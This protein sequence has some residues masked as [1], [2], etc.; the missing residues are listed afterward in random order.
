RAHAAA[1]HARRASRGEEG[2][3]HLPPARGGLR[4]RRHHGARLRRASLRGRRLRLRKRGAAVLRGEVLL[5]RADRGRPVWSGRRRPGVPVRRDLGPVARGGRR[6]VRVDDRRILTLRTIGRAEARV[7]LTVPET[8]EA[9]VPELEGAQA[10]A[11]A[12]EPARRLRALIEP[13]R[14]VP[15]I[16]FETER[17]VRRTRPRWW[18]RARY[19]LVYDVVT[20]RSHQLARTF[21]EL[22][23]RQL[24][25]GRPTLEQVS[26][27]LRERYGLRPLLVGKADRAQKLLR[28]LEGE[29]LARAAQGSREV[30]VVVLEEGRVA[31]LADESQLTVPVRGGSGED[32]CRDVLRTHFGSA[33]GQVR[34]LGTAASSG[35]RPVLEVWLARRVSGARDADA[36]GRLQWLPFHELLAGAGA[37]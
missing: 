5:P 27:A 31:L 21:Q 4:G 10:L 3:G 12:S 25:A 32:A 6:R 30:A 36:S 20:V 8:A 15:R 24:A 13:G 33:D 34:F 14:L 29:G 26:G 35:T 2:V 22:K 16:Q 17:R 9:E 11:G 1:A 19:E 37:P 18:R 23:I 7:P 28:D